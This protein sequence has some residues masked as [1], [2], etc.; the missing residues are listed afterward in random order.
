M[1]SG[2][3]E[4]WK[5]S[6]C[7]ARARRQKGV[8]FISAPVFAGRLKFHGGR[9]FFHTSHDTARESTFLGIGNVARDRSLSCGCIGPPP[10][11]IL[12]LEGNSLGRQTLISF[13]SGR[14][15]LSID[16][17]GNFKSS[18]SAHDHQLAVSRTVFGMQP[19][20]WDFQ[21][22]DR[23]WKVQQHSLTWAIQ[24]FSN[25]GMPVNLRRASDRIVGLL[26]T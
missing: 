22:G 25:D 11:D 2:R 3:Q 21:T 18:I 23:F 5:L 10:R 14:K 26:T 1:S 15:R 24:G 9:S 6:P 8:P 4:S 20:P 19:S 7:L 13:R 12:S 17:I 16:T